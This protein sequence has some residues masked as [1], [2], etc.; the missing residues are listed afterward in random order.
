[1]VKF[2]SFHLLLKFFYKHHVMKVVLEESDNCIIKD[3]SIHCS[4]GNFQSLCGNYST[5]QVSID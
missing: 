3:A 1:M 4:M 2:A 5:V